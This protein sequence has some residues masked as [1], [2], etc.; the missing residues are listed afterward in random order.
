M[1]K[2]TKSD[3]VLV[4]KEILTK[5]G[6]VQRVDALESQKTDDELHCQRS[7]KVLATSVL[8]RYFL[9]LVCLLQRLFFWPG[10]ICVF[11]SLS[12]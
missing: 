6:I 2:L 1:Y 4:E 11:D 5:K 7:N 10:Q 9:D 8:H 12:T 3:V